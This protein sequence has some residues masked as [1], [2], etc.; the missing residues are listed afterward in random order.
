MRPS[1]EKFKTSPRAPEALFR[2]AERVF[3][4]RQPQREAQARQLY[5]QV[6]DDYP[7]SEWAPRALLARRRVE[8]KMRSSG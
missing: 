6:V 8:D 5:S 3:R 1:V 4:S 7:Q 2:Q